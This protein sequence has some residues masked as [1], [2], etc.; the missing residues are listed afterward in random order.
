MSDPVLVDLPSEVAVKRSDPVYNAHAYLTKVPYSAI[1]PFV[2]TLTKP[3]DTVL[4]VFA[5]SGMTGVASALAGRD[6]ELR[7]ISALGRHIGRN[8]MRLLNADEVREA[9]EAVLEA[10]AKRL[11]EL[12]AVRCAGCGEIGTLSKTVWSFQYECPDCEQPVTYYEA[13]KESGWR[14]RSMKCSA[15]GAPFQTRGGKRTSEVPVL[16]Y[17]RCRCS[18]R[19]REQPHS[20]PLV[21][22]C[23]DD[24]D[25][26]DVE[27]G[28]DR[29]MFQASALKKHG[30][31]TT[32]AFFS[33][34]NLAVLAGLR[35]AIADL[36]DR[37]VRQKLMFA[38]TAILTRAS[39]RYQ[40]H[41]K[42][43]LN[44]SNQNYYIAPVFY[45]WNVYELFERKVEASIRSDRFIRDQMGLRGVETTASVN[46][47][48]ASAESL[49]LSDGS[50]DYVFT[51]PPF[52]SQIFYSD[53]NLFQEAWLDDFTDDAREAVVDRS[54]NGTTKRSAA[55]YEQLIV[56]AL[57]ECHRV[58]KDDGWLS[59][60]FSNSSGDAWLLVQRAIH[61][62]GLVL[63]HVTLLDK[64][65]RSVKGLASG[66]E[67]V[68]TSDLILTM[69]KATEADSAALVDAPAAALPEAIEEA[70]KQPGNLSPTKVYLWVITRYL[71]NEWRVSDITIGGIRDE[72]LARDCELNPATGELTIR[73]ATAA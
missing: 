49:D 20:R 5:G 65:Q 23:L 12:Y 31:L 13:F 71:R 57:R 56:D 39:K 7:D 6:A 28:P 68:V 1:L 34:R 17:V 27:I 10:A 44:A 14:K 53:M 64:G 51:D 4:D 9:G 45:E 15:C 47:K 66:F 35:A 16:D 37:A 69:R 21:P 73:T 33:D 30:L 29:Q 24:L 18:K 46:Y 58:L 50:I 52:G 41:P 25:Y 22:A 11:G 42:R 2:E 70:L 40:W 67:G 54:A 38:F 62:A 8:Y 26:P 59:L 3:G 32:S 61:A 19:I 43:P 36:E 48:I 60:V 55:R 72:L 63:E